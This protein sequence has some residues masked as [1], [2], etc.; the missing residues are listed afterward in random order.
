MKYLHYTLALLI[1]MAL[2]AC[3]MKEDTYSSLMV[4]YVNFYSEMLDNNIDV[5]QRK[6]ALNGKQTEQLYMMKRDLLSEI[7][8]VR[9]VLFEFQMKSAE[10]LEKDTVTAD[11]VA[12]VLDILDLYTRVFKDP[13]FNNFI[14]F[15]E[16]LNIQQKKKLAAMVKNGSFL[17]YRADYFPTGL[18]MKQYFTLQRNIHLTQQQKKQLFTSYRTIKRTCKNEKK[19]LIIQYHEMKEYSVAL[20][21]SDKIELS[22]VDMKENQ[23]RQVVKPIT[24]TTAEETATFINS[25][26]AE[27]KKTLAEFITGFTFM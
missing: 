2:S 4:R 23:F 11:E 16:S 6:L 24:E 20:I 18:F 27:Q 19:N 12:Q 3:S 17:P 25:L 8:E 21:L 9:Q 22:A 15:H 5:L 10:L 26:S 13:F 14:P 1:F 7:P